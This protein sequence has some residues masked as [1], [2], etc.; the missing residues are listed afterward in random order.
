MALDIWT[1][2]DAFPNPLCGLSIILSD[3]IAEDTMC[4]TGMISPYVLE[5]VRV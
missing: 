3:L 2:W 1:Y 4:L 5:I